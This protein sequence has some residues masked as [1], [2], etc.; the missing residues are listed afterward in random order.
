MP[1]GLGRLPFL[2]RRSTRQGSEPPPAPTVAVDP[3]L[4]PIGPPVLLPHA[5]IR[6]VLFE[7]TELTP[8]WARPRPAPEPA[9]VP[10]PAASRK[11]APRATAKS[12]APPSTPR[13]ARKPK[14]PPT[15][16]A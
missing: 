13:R 15:L 14:S 4:A 10:A 8:A 3:D 1:R 2:A 11:R 12:A 6:Q 9:T 7:A 5:I 16:D